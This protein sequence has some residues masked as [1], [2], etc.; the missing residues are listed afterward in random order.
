MRTQPKAHPMLLL[1]AAVIA[2]DASKEYVRCGSVAYWAIALSLVPITG[3]VSAVAA[4]WLT[5]KYNTKVAAGRS[6]RKGEVRRACRP[7]AQVLMQRKVCQPL[8]LWLHAAADIV[9][10]L[11]QVAW[12]PRNTVVYPAL[13][14]LA[15]LVAGMFGV[16]GGIVKVGYW[17][18][19]CSLVD[20]R[21]PVWSSAHLHVTRCAVCFLC[22][23]PTCR[24]EVI[25]RRTQGPLMLEMGVLPDV[26]AATSATMIMCETRTAV[27]PLCLLYLFDGAGQYL[28]GWLQSLS[29]FT[30]PLTSTP[31]TAWPLMCSVL[32]QVHLSISV[33]RL[34]RLWHRQVRAA[35]HF[36]THASE[37]P[38]HGRCAS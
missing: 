9:Y 32:A 35:H 19:A 13:C 28:V 37:R 17:P 8:R 7:V 2:S 15:G 12:T 11:L 10:T 25:D 30:A 31:K 29:L 38:C 23:M 26:A 22:G 36:L 20:M 3:A 16:G 14:S 34:H 21:A 18:A 6:L 27:S 24:L 1:T 4:R 33:S 5:R